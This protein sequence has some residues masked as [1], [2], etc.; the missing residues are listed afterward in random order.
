MVGLFSAFE[1]TVAAA[2]GA[3]SFTSA[4]RRPGPASPR[5]ASVHDMSMLRPR[6]DRLRCTSAARI[7]YA[8]KFAPMWSMYEKP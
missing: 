8:M 7:A 3:R 1:S 5:P 2:R 4:S 6:P